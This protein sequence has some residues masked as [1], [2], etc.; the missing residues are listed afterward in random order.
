MQFREVQ[1]ARPGANCNEPQLT[2]VSIVFQNRARI[3][4]P[5]APEFLPVPFLQ[6]HSIRIRSMASW[7]IRSFRRS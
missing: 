5:A 2:A 3:D 6:Y 7:V 4:F 1:K